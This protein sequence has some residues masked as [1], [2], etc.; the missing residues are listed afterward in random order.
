MRGG[1]YGQARF[2]LLVLVAAAMPMLGAEA[3]EAFQLRKVSVVSDEDSTTTAA[4]P[5]TKPRTQHP[6]RPPR[7]AAMAP[8]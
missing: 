1:E 2:S 5:P 7:P 6:A 3:A 4:P 8:T